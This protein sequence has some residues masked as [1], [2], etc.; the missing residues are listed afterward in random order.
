MLAKTNHIH[1]ILNEMKEIKIIEIGVYHAE[2]AR[3]CIRRYDID[4]YILID[5]YI[6]LDILPERYGSKRKQKKIKKLLIKI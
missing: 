2:N 4:L 6:K 3:E 5:P 1:Q